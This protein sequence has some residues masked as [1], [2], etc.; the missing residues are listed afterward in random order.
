MIIYKRQMIRTAGEIAVQERGQALVTGDSLGQVASQTLANINAIYDVSELPLL[1]P[2]IGWDKE[3]IITLARRIGTY[4][5]SI[6][7]YCDICSFLISKHPQTAGKKNK[8]AELEALLPLQGLDCTTQIV[9]FDM[10]R[11]LDEK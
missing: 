9:R 7:E 4:E 3:E 11:E 8:V 10:G 5:I 1:P 2:L 6:E